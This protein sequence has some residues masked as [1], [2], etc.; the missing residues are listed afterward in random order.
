MEPSKEST[1]HLQTVR[2]SSL[3]RWAVAL[4]WFGLAVF[5]LALGLGFLTDMRS[6]VGGIT[7]IAVLGML[8]LLSLVPARFIL[9]VQLMSPKSRSGDSK[10]TKR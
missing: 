1:R 2:Q 9:T 6:T 7:T 10:S 3:F 8:G 4:Q 5:L